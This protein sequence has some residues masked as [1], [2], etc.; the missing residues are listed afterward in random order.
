MSNLLENYFDC[1][2]FNR[3]IRG[4]VITALFFSFISCSSDEELIRF[5]PF[6]NFDANKNAQLSKSSEFIIVIPDIQFY[7]SNDEYGEFL[8]AMIKR[9]LEI[10]KEGYKIK[11]VF[12]VGDITQNNA[13]REWERAL[14]S[15]SQLDGQIN[16]MLGIGNHDYGDGGK[17]NNRNTYFNDYFHFGNNAF[18][19]TSYQDNA[20]QNSYFQFDIHERP[21]QLFLLEFGPRDEVVTWADSIAKQHK[22]RQGMLLTHAYLDEDLTRYDF[23]GRG[24]A[25]GVSPYYYSQ[26]FSDYAAGGVN[27]GQ[28]LWDKLVKDNKFEM[29]ICGHRNG[30]ESLFSRNEKGEEVMQMV[31]AEHRLPQAV[32]GWI[33]ILEFYEDN[34]GIGVKTYSTI[35]N[36]W[37]TDTAHQ[38]SFDYTTDKE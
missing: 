27:D 26:N 38:Y 34:S 2:R 15:F 7:S 36:T 6:S 20:Y 13:L 24:W 23:A 16:Y 14:K 37:K 28:E 8:D 9:I 11:A 33:R 1:M 17:S 18:Y 3:F 22:D 12:Q 25:Q 29:V 30:S 4:S 21:Y 10:K 31:F 19:I 35:S 32:E 5:E